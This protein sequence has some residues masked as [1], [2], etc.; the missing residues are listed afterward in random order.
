ML[1]S[2]PLG[3]PKDVLLGITLFVH[4]FRDLGYASTAIRASPQ[5]KSHKDL[6]FP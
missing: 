2:G 3:R 1:I 6:K 4:A 5:A